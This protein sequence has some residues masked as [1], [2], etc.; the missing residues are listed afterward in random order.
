MNQ[1]TDLQ[2]Y[3]IHI[4]AKIVLQGI[5]MYGLGNWNEVAEHV[6]TK[7]KSQC[8]HHYNMI[9][10]NSPCFPLP[11]CPFVSTRI[12]TSDCFKFVTQSHL[13]YFCHVDLPRICPMSWARTERNSLLWPENRKKS[14]KVSHSAWACTHTCMYMC[15]SP[16]PPQILFVLL[17]S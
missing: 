13:I 2:S 1:P 11:V 15:H 16:L 4:M 8:V 17:M 14:T 6:G 9:Y 7:S 3:Q 5:E 12:C 10:M